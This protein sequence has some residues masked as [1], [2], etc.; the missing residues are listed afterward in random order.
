MNASP[1]VSQGQ[2]A[3]LL[4]TFGAAVLTRIQAAQNAKYEPRNSQPSQVNSFQPGSLPQPPPIPH[5]SG[6]FG[7]SRKPASGSQ[8]AGSRPPIH[9]LVSLEQGEPRILGTPEV[10]LPEETKQ[11]LQMVRVHE[12]RPQ[13]RYGAHRL[14]LSRLPHGQL[15]LLLESLEQLFSVPAVRELFCRPM[16]GLVYDPPERK[17][18]SSISR[19]LHTGSG[20][21]SPVCDGAL[22]DVSS[23]ALS[24][25]SGGA[26]THSSFSRRRSARSRAYLAVALEDGHLLYGAHAG[27]LSW[28]T[29]DHPSLMR[30][31]RS[32]VRKLSRLH[33]SGLEAGDTSCRNLLLTNDGEVLLISAGHLSNLDRRSHGIPEV[34]VLLAQFARDLDANDLHS[35]LSA[36]LEGEGARSRA[37]AYLRHHHSSSRRTRGKPYSPH[38]GVE[39][40]L[41]ARVEDLADPIPYSAQA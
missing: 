31:L 11:F 28:G 9:S 10:A 25:A 35:L 26:L 15:S 16:G 4:A 39:E 7:G 19:A 22:S 30:S 8:V 41:I 14:D 23:S 3:L 12:R 27:R 37:E 6:S 20:E 36:Y 5:P 38:I 18:R 29:L 13:L 33:S 34:L 1:K 40:R 17:M 24:R 2:K 21:I 32:L